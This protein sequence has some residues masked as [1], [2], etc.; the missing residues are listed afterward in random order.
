MQFGFIINLSEK[1]ERVELANMIRSNLERVK[2]HGQRADGIVKSMLMHSRENSGE[3]AAED[4]NSTVEDSLNLAY[5]G[6]RSERER[7][8]AL[9]KALDPAA[10]RVAMFRQDVTRALLNIISN[11]IY[12]TL[13]QRA[14]QSDETYES[15]LKVTTKNL[16]EAVQIVILDNGEGIAPENRSKIFNPFFTTKPPGE[17]TGLGLSLSHDII[18]KQHGGMIDLAILPGGLPSSR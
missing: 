8:V 13:K 9:D 15:A 3:W 16:G 4:I 7:Q 12:A 17:G 6:N 5:Y 11:G 10:G 2:Q 18:V 14:K 1:S